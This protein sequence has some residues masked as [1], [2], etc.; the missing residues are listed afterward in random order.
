MDGSS[1]FADV[2]IN[3][4]YGVDFNQDQLQPEDLR[5]VCLKLQAEGVK[6]FLA[7]VI[8]A[9]IEAM[10]RRISA[11]AKL[12]DAD[13]IVA[14]VLAGIHV[15]GPFISPKP[16]CPG[17]HPRDAIREPRIE[18]AARLV[19]AGQGLVRLVTLAPECDR[20]FAVTKWLSRRGILVAAG[21]SD[22][23]IDELRGAIDAG[24]SFFTH[25]GNGCAIQMHRHDNIIQRVLSLADR[26][27]I[28]FIAD[29]VHVPWFALK[30]YISLVGNDRAIIVSDAMAAAGC[31]PGAYQIGDQLVEADDSGAVWAAD[32]THLAG[33]AALMPQMADNLKTKLGLSPDVVQRLTYYNAL[34][35]ISAH[36]D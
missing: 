6:K 20:R 35:A 30:N 9:D 21:H 33:S 4:C 7:T 32:R 14:H 15:E 23:S 1:R 24:L 25:L 26:L 16:G 19:D 28:T 34:N 8:S 31:G 3:G 5:R 18:L 17:A 22:A 13:P 12:R 10:E 11:I 2:Q 27:W 36:Q 29:G